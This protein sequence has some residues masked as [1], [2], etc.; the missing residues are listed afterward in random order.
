MKTRLFLGVAGA[1]SVLLASLTPSPPT[2]AAELPSA[3]VAQQQTHAGAPGASILAL[4]SFDDRPKVIDPKTY[5]KS[6]GPNLSQRVVFTYD[7]CPNSLDALK[8]VL[9]YVSKP[10]V[11]IGLVFAPTGQCIRKYKKKHKVD[12][13]TLMS[14]HGQYV[15]NHSYSHPNLTKRSTAN[16]K[17]QITR[18]GKVSYG[19][20]PYGA[21]NKKV[22]KAY[23]AVGMREWIW[24]VDTRDWDGKTSVEVQTYVGTHAC[25]GC[26]VLMHMQ[27]KGFDPTAI[28]NMNVLIQKRG[29]YLCRTFRGWANPAGGPVRTTPTWWGNNALPC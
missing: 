15:I 4:Q 28:G 6:R 26:T 7:D 16:I 17:W 21:T 23:A 5:N 3:R 2:Q 1:V 18:D 19:R 13:T 25:A 11:N 8:K 12:I 24:N 27:H 9:A 20:P 14:T 29:L 22:A 10:E